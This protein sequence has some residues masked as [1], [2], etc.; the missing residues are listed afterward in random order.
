MSD[1]AEH[2]EP[3]GLPDIELVTHPREEVGQAIMSTL[4]SFRYPG[5]A[6]CE[7]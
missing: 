4:H 6:A 2:C 5:T 3:G 7:R 1:T